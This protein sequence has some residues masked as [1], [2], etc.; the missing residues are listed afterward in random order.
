[1]KFILNSTFVLSAALLSAKTEQDN[2]KQKNIEEVIV[3]AR[4]PTVE[5]KVDRTIFNV[6]N[7]SIVSGNTTWDVLRMTPLV[8]IDSDDVVKNLKVKA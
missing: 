8:S 7:S 4:K 3:I 5:N 6:A 2:I 1:M